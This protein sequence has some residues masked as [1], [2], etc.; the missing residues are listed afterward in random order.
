[1][2][3]SNGRWNIGYSGEF[4][5]HPA[6]KDKPMKT[7]TCKE[8]GGTCDLQLTAATWDEM[9]KLMTQHVMDKHS[10]VA[11]AME[12]MYKQDP[13]QWGKEMKPKWE[14]AAELR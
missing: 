2:I 4:D 12:Q 8:L 14:A 3:M 11:K 1:M 7:M 6:V 9:V 10:D 5:L 13:K